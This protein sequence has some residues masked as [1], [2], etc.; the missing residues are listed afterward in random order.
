LVIRSADAACLEARR[1]QK[2]S[3]HWRSND[4]HASHGDVPFGQLVAAVIADPTFNASND[5][6]MITAQ[7]LESCQGR[8]NFRQHWNDQCGNLLIGAMRGDMPAGYLQGIAVRI[9][10]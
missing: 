4:S 6:L 10:P 7:C 8:S 5:P 3:V 1:V 9:N 2:A